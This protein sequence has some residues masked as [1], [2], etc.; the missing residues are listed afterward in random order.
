[1]IQFNTVIQRFGEQGE[2][3]GWTYIVIPVKIAQ[4]LKPGNKKSFRVKGKLDNHDITGVALLPMGEGDFIMA[5]NAGMRKAIGKRKGDKLRVELTVDE[6]PPELCAELLECLPDEPVAQEY[7]DS[8]PY[9]HRLYF[10]K[11]IESAKSAPTKA[12]RIAQAVTALSRKWGFPEMIR[13]NKRDK[14]E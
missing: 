5:L 12:K 6:K 1:M 13:A 10:S 7:F 11:W 4:Q 9:S 8:L 3:T 2:K 14:N